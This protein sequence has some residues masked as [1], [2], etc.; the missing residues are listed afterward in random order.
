[1]IR[2]AI[3]EVYYQFI[4][5]RIHFFLFSRSS[6]DVG[7][8]PSAFPF[9]DRS[10]LDHHSAARKHPTTPL[11]HS[12]DPHDPDHTGHA[13]LRELWNSTTATVCFIY[14]GNNCKSIIIIVFVIII[15]ICIILGNHLA[16]TF[17]FLLMLLCYYIQW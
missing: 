9:P 4:L 10:R 16:I 5:K 1:M 17:T 12:A 8:D 11:Q 7:A 13:S 15:I 14:N 6:R 3:T 2:V